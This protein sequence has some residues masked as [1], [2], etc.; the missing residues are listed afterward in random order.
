MA[1]YNKYRPTKFEDVIGQDLVKSVLQNA[2][3]HNQIKHGY[4]LSGPKGTGKT[5]M[6]RIFANQLNDIDNQPQSKIDIV[7][8]DAAS[9]TGVDNIRQLI[10]S[11]MVPP[12]AGKYKI[13]II[14]EVHM[15]SKSAMNA[16]LKILEEPPSYLIFLLATTNPEKLLPTV[17]SRLTKLSL[18][19][20]TLTD[21][22]SRLTFIA[23]TENMQI[24]S[25]SINLVAKRAGG[26]QRDGIN[27]LETLY[28]YHLPK[29]DLVTTSSLLGVLPEKLFIQLSQDFANNDST[30]L[31]QTIAQIEQL[32][33]DGETFLGQYLEFLLD[34]SFDDKTDF[35]FLIMPIANILNLKLPINSPTAS[36]ALVRANINHNP[37]KTISEQK[38]N[39]KNLELENNFDQ[40]LPNP[41]NQIPIPDQNTNSQIPAKP[42]EQNQEPKPAQ[43]E[44]PQLPNTELLDKVEIPN[45]PPTTSFE[46]QTNDN[47]SKIELELKSNATD[48]ESDLEPISQSDISLD[49]ILSTIQ[50]ITAQKSCPPILKMIAPD[51]A[52]DEFEAGILQISISSPLFLPQ[53]K[54]PLHQ[55]FL[56]THLQQN[57]QLPNLEIIFVLRTNTKPKLKVHQSKT[58]IAEAGIPPITKIPGQKQNNVIKYKQE[59]QKPPSSQ[60]PKFVPKDLG[61]IFY[62]VY[63]CFPEQTVGDTSKIP[64]WQDKIPAPIAKP[65]TQNWD[66][67]IGSMFEL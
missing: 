34:L 67:E 44:S 66:D 23:K 33:L 6:A 15:L 32:G 2:I 7:E 43:L 56:K 9:N 54:S 27:F 1:W 25:D 36:I 49:H 16:L 14:D 11:A 30:N 64:V 18:T 39:S 50:T 59:E 47:I 3:R 63:Q 28:S 40:D 13:Y 10:E 53:I 21:I 55:D 35:D 42:I 41:T 17:L 48:L 60:T 29:Y 51:I 26:G 61:K 8:L 46:S 37:E 12:F 20:H 5:T 58:P 19:S 45:S 62:S 31:K 65:Q 57:L 52:V 4:L 22:A 24:D 38:K